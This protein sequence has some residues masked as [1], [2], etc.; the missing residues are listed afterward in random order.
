M[1]NPVALAAAKTNHFKEERC[2]HKIKEF[3]AILDGFCVMGAAVIHSLTCC[4]HTKILLTLTLTN[5]TEKESPSVSVDGCGD[6][7][8][9]QE[10]EISVQNQGICQM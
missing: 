2:Q 9:I 7:K 4:N 3:A 5:G 8:S 6:N 1:A 10:R